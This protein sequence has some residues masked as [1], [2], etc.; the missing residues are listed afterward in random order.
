MANK[1]KNY[2][3]CCCNGYKIFALDEEDTDDDDAPPSFK[4]GD[5][6]VIVVVID[7]LALPLELLLV[8]LSGW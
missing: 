7:P 2:C 4:L 6:S 1:T 3:C 8:L 5:V